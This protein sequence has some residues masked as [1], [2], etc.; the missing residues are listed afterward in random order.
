MACLKIYS[1]GN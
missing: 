1:T